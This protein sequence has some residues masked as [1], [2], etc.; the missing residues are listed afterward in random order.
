M[1]AANVTAG[2]RS[3]LRV[4]GLQALN[5]RSSG[6]AALLARFACARRR[7]QHLS[8]A[9]ALNRNVEVTAHVQQ[10]PFDAEQVSRQVSFLH[11]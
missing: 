9:V 7:L 1:R 11:G 2:H 10:L 5:V 3:V 8:N 6:C 4:A